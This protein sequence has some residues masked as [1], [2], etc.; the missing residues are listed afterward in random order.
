MFN[1]FAKKNTKKTLSS[2]EADVKR[3]SA[4]STKSYV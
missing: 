3:D 4:V 2:S 1:Y